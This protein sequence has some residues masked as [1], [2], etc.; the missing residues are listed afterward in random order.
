MLPLAENGNGYGLLT[1][2]GRQANEF[3]RSKDAQKNKNQ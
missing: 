1:R 3:G 2:R